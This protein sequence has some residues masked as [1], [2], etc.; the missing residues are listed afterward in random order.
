MKKYDYDKISLLKN[1]ERWFPV[2]GEIHYSRVPE[3]YWK[4]ELLKMK[5]GGVDIISSYVIWIHHEEIE[6]EWDFE[7]QKNLRKFVRLIGDCNLTMILR[8]GPWCHGEVRNGGFP[9]WLFQKEFEPRTNDERY[10][11]E[12]EK[13]YKKIYSEVQGL[14]LKDG[15]PIIGV[16][17]ENEFGHCGGLWGKNGEKHMKRL[18]NMAR[19]I[20]F[21]VPLYTATGWGGAITA[22]LLPVM[23]GYCDAPWDSRT[24][25]IE[26]SG[27]YIFTYERNDHAIGSDYGLGQGITFDMEKVP[28]L[29]AELGGGLQVTY[30]RR[31][32]A[33]STDIGAMTLTKMGSGCNLLGYYMYH[34]GTNPKGK[35]TT[36]EESTETGYPNDLPVLNYDFRAP[37]GE[38]GDFGQTFNELKLFSMFVHEWGKDFCKMLPHI[39]EDNPIHP[40]NFND[41]RYSW[42]YEISNGK[43]SGFVFVNNYVR[44]HNM[45]EHKNTILSLAVDIKN[46]TEE[47]EFPI[48]DISDK[49]YFFLPFNM[50]VGGNNLRTS[51]ATPLTA[52]HNEKPT[53]IFYTKEN[54]LPSIKAVSYADLKIYQFENIKNENCDILTLSRKDA[55]KSFVIKNNSEEILALTDGAFVESLSESS[56]A[57]YSLYSKTVPSFC[58]DIELKKVPEH[59]VF[60][61]KYGDMFEYRYNSKLPE[62]PKVTFEKQTETSEK[63]VYKISV[64]ALEKNELLHDVMLKINYTGNCARLYK[65]GELI[66]DNLY[67]GPSYDWEI[68][69][70]KFGN[71][72]QNFVLEIDSLKK[73]APLYLEQWPEMAEDSILELN[74]ITTETRYKVEI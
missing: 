65:N 67:I 19:K 74:E 5:A 68:G 15:G 43:K 22:G 54:L 37:I 36:L 48:I 40:E 44:R 50:N 62:A 70:R 8:I 28:Y 72:K 38:Y 31:P 30:K 18:Y 61:S 27:N 25:E 57:K 35:K 52:L 1:K 46:K 17:I 63:S 26:P 10:F 4:E 12:V 66:A 73:N 56:T 32:V 51:L 64:D 60:S 33:T 71:E 7:G 3:R 14:F 21:K 58:T 11:T 24:T 55:L 29:T 16:Q 2:M 42:R 59:F 39:P 69:L 23:G 20:G 49:D 47:I 13:F 45:A 6:N 53:Y 34:G 9:D 41:L